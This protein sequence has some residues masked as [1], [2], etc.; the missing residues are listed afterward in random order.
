M[1]IECNKCDENKPKEEA[2]LCDWCSK[3]FHMTCTGIGRNIIQHFRTN[4][5]LKWFCD[6][7]LDMM[8]NIRMNLAV[9]NNHLKKETKLNE[10]C[11]KINKLEKK[12]DEKCG[13]KEDATMKP[14]SYADVIKYDKNESV[15]IIK[16]KKVDQKCNETRAE[17]KSKVNPMNIPILGM[18]NDAKGGIIV[19]LENKVGCESMKKEVKEK[20]GENY[21]VLSPELKNPRIKIIGM[22][23]K[24]TEEEVMTMMKQNNVVKDAS[25]KVLAVFE[26]R[27]G[28]RFKA[29]NAIVEIDATNFNN[30]M[31]VRKLYM[32]WD[33]CLVVD[34]AQITR[35]YKCCGYNHMAK[36]CRNKKSCGR[37]GGEHD[38]KEC[39]ST[40][41]VC[42]NCKTATERTGMN[43]RFDHPV[44]SNECTVYD[45]KMEMLRRKI[46]YAE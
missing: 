21:D 42:I 16:P 33:R 26:D 1:S 18:R 32:K 30:I 40:K 19:Q 8:K 15:V 5:N 37:C 23:D 17:I 43:L 39:K 9:I 31:C 10:I 12:I 6:L 41:N 2:I 27:K 22:T 20:L 35:C 36:D 4:E 45:R 46:K 13:A 44:W 29:Y 7:C 14:K 38:L 3:S 24:P 34:A 11:E 25:L 28:G